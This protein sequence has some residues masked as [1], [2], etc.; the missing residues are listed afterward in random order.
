MYIKSILSPIAFISILKH[1]FSIL[2]NLL[3]SISQMKNQNT[4]LVVTVI[5]C[6]LFMNM[7]QHYEASRILAIERLHDH[8]QNQ[9][10]LQALQ[11][12]P[13]PPMGGNSCTYIPGN[14]G[15][16]CTNQRNFAGHAVQASSS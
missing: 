6:V 4:L 8:H 10:L 12:G 15:P 7:M 3:S 9:F 16:P 11:K 13:V 5:T 14:G 2:I 1:L